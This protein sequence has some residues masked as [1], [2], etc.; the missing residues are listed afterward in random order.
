MEVTENEQTEFDVKQRVHEAVRNP[1]KCPCCIELLKHYDE[2][3]RDCYDFNPSEISWLRYNLPLIPD[4][5]KSTTAS[6]IIYWLHKDPGTNPYVIS[7]RLGVHYNAVV[8]W[9]KKFQRI[10]L[11]KISEFSF[12]NKSKYYLNSKLP[13]LNLLLV[14]LLHETYGQSLHATMS[15]NINYHWETLKR[16]RKRN[17]AIAKRHRHNYEKGY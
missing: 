11:I 17:P 6:G 10:G 15:R 4:L 12:A 1:S 2:D 9:I 14:D 5:L 7:K 13:N 3:G 8:H 16:Y